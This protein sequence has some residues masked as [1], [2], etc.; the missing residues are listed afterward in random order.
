MNLSEKMTNEL[1][2]DLHNLN[3]DQDI[4]EVM[5]S[6][7]SNSDGANEPGLPGP[8]IMYV[9]ETR[10]KNPNDIGISNGDSYD[11]YKNIVSYLNEHNINYTYC[12]DKLILTYNEG[13]YY[14]LQLFKYKD[15]YIVRFTTATRDTRNIEGYFSMSNLKD[16]LSNM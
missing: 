6:Q 14:E 2:N 13:T 10:M 1:K 8:P 7:T 12:H 9:P 4:N 15:S 16:F 3:L 11:I 5:D